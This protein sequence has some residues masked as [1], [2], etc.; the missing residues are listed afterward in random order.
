MKI[1]IFRP[2]GSDPR[3]RSCLNQRFYQWKLF[4]PLHP[5]FESHVRDIVEW[6]SSDA[7]VLSP[8]DEFIG[9]VGT[10]ASNRRKAA[11]SPVS[12]AGFTSMASFHSYHLIG[13]QFAM[14]L[15]RGLIRSRTPDLRGPDRALQ[16]HPVEYTALIPPAG[17]YHSPVAEVGAYAHGKSKAAI[18]LLY[19]GIVSGLHD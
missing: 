8:A 19:D 5:A 1:C 11:A 13:K 7:A 12:I 18:F 3:S 16:Q 6:M 10:S 17:P 2:S 15:P 4:A 9:S 14:R